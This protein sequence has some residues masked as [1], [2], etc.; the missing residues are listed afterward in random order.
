MALA[1]IVAY[2]ARPDGNAAELSPP[3]ASPGHLKRSHLLV[4]YNG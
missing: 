3:S 4:R 1:L 2:V